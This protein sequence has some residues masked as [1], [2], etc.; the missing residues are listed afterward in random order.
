MCIFAAVLYG[1]LHD[2]ITARVCL[3][4]FT[5]FHPPVFATQS[6]TRWQIALGDGRR[7]TLSWLASLL[8]DATRHRIPAGM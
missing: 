2:Q 4:Y 1:V 6:P 7:C 3:E 5:V 8:L